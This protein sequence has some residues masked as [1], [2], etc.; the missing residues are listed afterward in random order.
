MYSVQQR[1]NTNQFAPL[2]IVFHQLAF[3]PITASRLLAKT[4]K[5]TLVEM[6]PTR[7]DKTERTS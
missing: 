1:L 4:M 6:S 2:T 7:P 3:H 5:L